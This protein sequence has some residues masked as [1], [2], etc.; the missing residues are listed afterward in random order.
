MRKLCDSLNSTFKL[1]IIHRDIKSANI[2]IT[3]DGV[4]KIFDFGLA[5]FDISIDF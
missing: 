1:G 5:L 4:A 3:H 2:G